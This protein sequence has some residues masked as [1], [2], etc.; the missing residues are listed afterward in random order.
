M[1]K[2]LTCKY[3]FA[4]AA[5]GVPA[6]AALPPA[7]L[8]RAVALAPASAFALPAVF[9]LAPA[10]EFVAVGDCCAGA[11]FM[12]IACSFYQAFCVSVRCAPLVSI[13]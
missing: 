10:G 11:S 3:G 2:P 7:W 8:V 12:P 9:A 4:G 6:P 13:T 5:A 1:H